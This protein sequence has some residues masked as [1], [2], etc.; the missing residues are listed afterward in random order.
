MTRMNFK[1]FSGNI[2]IDSCAGLL[3]DDD[4]NVDNDR[5]H[6]DEDWK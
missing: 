6:D 3:V 4:Y 5:G 1:S 2:T